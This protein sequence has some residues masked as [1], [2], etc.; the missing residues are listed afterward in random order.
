MLGLALR[1][2]ATSYGV[3][4][5]HLLGLL[6]AS[7]LGVWGLIFFLSR[8]SRTI[9]ASRFVAVT[10][11]ILLAVAAFE[12]MAALG[13]V[14]YRGVFNIPTPK[15]RRPGFRPDPELIYVRE[16]NRRERW[17]CLGSERYRLRGG[18]PATVYRCD[19]RLD[20]DGFR[21]PPGIDPPDVAIV[22]DS[23]IEGP[24]RSANPN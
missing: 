10:G 9:E 20:G 15:W 7:Y 14:D 8:Q 19:L 11:S 12:A 3:T 2:G 21:N 24:H 22:G 23:F 5:E 18:S 6:M 1:L 17:D 16:G 4:P 13:L